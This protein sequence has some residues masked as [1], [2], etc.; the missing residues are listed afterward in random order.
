MKNVA[1]ILS[2]VMAAQ[3]TLAFAQGATTALQ[4]TVPTVR[5]NVTSG[6]FGALMVAPQAG[7]YDITDTSEYV[8]DLVKQIQGVQ[9]SDVKYIEDTIRALM[10]A[11]NE[12]TRLLTVGAFKQ[13]SDLTV[14]SKTLDDKSVTQ[15]KIKVEKF[16]EVQNMV[17]SAKVAL[18]TKRDLLTSIADSLPSDPVITEGR[19]QQKVV[20]PRHID[21]SKT[22]NAVNAAID[23]AEALAKNYPFVIEH[24]QGIQIVNRN[25]GTALNIQLNFPLLTGKAIAN[26]QKKARELSTPSTVFNDELTESQ[27]MLLKK[28]IV[29]FVYTYGDKEAYR[30]RDQALANARAEALAKIVDIFWQRSYLRK[31]QGVRVGAILPNTYD[32]R[33]L[34]WD[35]F[36]VTM[37]QLKGFK[38]EATGPSQ[39]TDDEMQ[40]ATEDYRQILNVLDQRSSKILSG[41]AS[42]LA[43]VNSAIT[44]ARG[45]RPTAESMLLI[46][47]LLAADL[48]EEYELAIGGGLDTVVKMYNQRWLATEED[49]KKVD[50]RVCAYDHIFNAQEGKSNCYMGADNSDSLKGIFTRMNDELQASSANI[51]QA[52]KIRNEIRL[53]MLAQS[54]SKEGAA[55]GST[56]RRG[57]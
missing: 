47:Q 38:K 16:L 41:D 45:E 15:G 29:G 36:A 55:N 48:K 22:M 33:Y 7:Q 17:N 51:E 31:V 6:G 37:D 5:N 42:I 27:G 20:N 57:R 56:S 9:A 44:L 26:L 34:N 12:Y 2:L 54:M 39:V 40:R 35:V 4:N 32:K 8:R 30:F 50:E 23:K 3:S 25:S 52:L 1:S 24:E 49:G 18:E 21:F 46:V 10:D 28:Q 14:A 13:M 43:R 19:T 11:T 53:A